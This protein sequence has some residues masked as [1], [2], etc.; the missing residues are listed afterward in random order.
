MA[1]NEAAKKRAFPPKM[2]PIITPLL[3]TFSRLVPAH[4]GRAACPFESIKQ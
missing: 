3:L 4:S 1:K 2:I